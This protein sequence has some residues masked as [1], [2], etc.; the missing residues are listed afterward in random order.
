MNTTIIARKINERRHRPN[1]VITTGEVL[2][3]VGSAGMQEA[4]QRNWLVP[5]LDT[6]YLM[7]NFNAGKLVELA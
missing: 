3:I 6:G 4:I 1:P 2:S 5:D 7:V